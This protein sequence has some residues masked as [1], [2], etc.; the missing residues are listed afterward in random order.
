VIG[1]AAPKVPGSARA[2]AQ[3]FFTFDKATTKV[4]SKN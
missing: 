2:Q 3:N 4:S 1:N